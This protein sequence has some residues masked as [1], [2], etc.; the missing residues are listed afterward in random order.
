M[1]INE[2]NNRYQWRNNAKNNGNGEKYG[3]VIARRAFT[4]R[5][6]RKCRRARE[7]GFKKIQAI[8]RA[9]MCARYR[10]SR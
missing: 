4:E 3:E 9:W 7:K 2:K 5:L 1:G 8:Y 10:K 6:H